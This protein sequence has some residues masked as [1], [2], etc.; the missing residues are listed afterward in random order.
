MYLAKHPKTKK[1]LQTLKN[2]CNSAEVLFSEKGYY[3]TSI[4]DIVY[5]A[6]VAPGTFYIYFNDK[7]SIFQ[8]LISDLGHNLL[9]EISTATKTA[10][11]RYEAESIGLRVFLNFVKK[12]SELYRI[13]W[14]AMF[15][16]IDIFKQYYESFSEK[17]IKNIIQAQTK[18]EM[19][20][21]DP[22][23]LS[24]CLIG[25]SNFIGLKFIIFDDQEI[26]D[27]L[28]D[29]IMSFIHNGAFNQ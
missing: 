11:T 27:E 19:R 5:K 1:G 10:H 3:E 28:I 17:Y 15:V 23:V 2:L 7:K 16:D 12:H 26:T 21:I 9:V 13:I 20:D 14:Q 24:Y 6:N 18:G 8:H 29:E 25:I 22:K 4:N